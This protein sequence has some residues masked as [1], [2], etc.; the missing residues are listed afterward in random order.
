MLNLRLHHVSS[1]AVQ[2]R[3]VGSQLAR[4]LVLG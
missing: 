2:S 4:D 3:L 1:Y